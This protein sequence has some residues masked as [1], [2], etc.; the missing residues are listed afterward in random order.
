MSSNSWL[1]LLVRGIR[2]EAL[3]AADDVHGAADLRA[4]SNGSVDRR[5]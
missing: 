5:G 4:G 3:R 1:E 2:L